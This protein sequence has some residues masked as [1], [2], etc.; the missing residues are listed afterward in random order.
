MKKLILTAAIVCS[1]I[2]AHGA[3]CLWTFEPVD[4]VVG[5]DNTGTYTGSMSIYAFAKGATFDTA[6]AIYSWD[7]NVNSGTF[8][9]EEVSADVF[10]PDTTYSFCLYGKEGNAEYVG[11][12]TNGKA[13]IIG[14]RGVNLKAGEW[15]G[16]VPEPT[17]GLM[18]ALGIGL[19]SLRRRRA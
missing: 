4:P 10:V 15:T 17:T 18:L 19:M 6:A 12:M 5:V 9:M 13:T 7:V 14:V 16:S 2:I 1:A 8:L 3:S 11:T